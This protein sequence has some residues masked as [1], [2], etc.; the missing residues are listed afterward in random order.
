MKDKALM[1][2]PGLLGDFRL[3]VILF[4]SFRLIMLLV[5]QP[6]VIDGVERGIGAGGDLLTYY[7]MAQLTPDYGPPFQGWWAEFPPVWPLLFNGV[8]QFLGRNANYTS[9]AMLLALMMLTLDVGNLMLMRAIGTQLHGAN[10][11]TAL[12][13]IYAL[14]VAPMIFLAWT[15]ETLVA[16]TVLLALWLFG[17]FNGTR[18]ALVIGIGTLTKFTPVLLLGAV[19]RFRKVKH[20]LRHTV[21]AAGMFAGVYL[22]LFVQDADMTLPSLTAQFNKSSYQ[23]IWALIDGN[24]KTGS[25]GPLEDRLYPERANIP[26]GNPA[27]IPVWLRL[28]VAVA[29][30]LFVF[31]RTRRFDH[32]GFVAFA[33]ITL[34]IFFLQAQGWSPQWLVQIIPLVLLCFPTR[35]GVLVTLLLSFAAFAEYPFLF[36]RTGDTH[37]EITGA[38]V[39]PFVM[40]IV[41]RTLILV[42]VCVGLYRILRQ[43]AVP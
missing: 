20:A 18:A 24:Y 14:S 21:I 41:A 19:W 30:G 32:K 29:V 40:L 17:R 9:F 11:G 1:T 28:G 7:G 13:W 26:L 43:E 23:T 39:M 6:L 12:A 33:T 22:I 15:F 5:Y 8:Y 35:T 3:L 2:I 34:L 10:T 25:F 38:F 31:L 36:I 16:F 4:L 42:G 37:G 27:R